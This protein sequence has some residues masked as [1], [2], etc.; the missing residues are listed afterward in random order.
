MPV[1]IQRRDASG[2]RLGALIQR[3]RGQGDAFT[4]ALSHREHAVAIAALAGGQGL[5]L[6]HRRS[7]DLDLGLDRPIEL[8]RPYTSSRAP[9]MGGAVEHWQQRRPQMIDSAV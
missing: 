5:G 2:D 7:A 6:M 3:H 4:D 1:E 8:P 9:S